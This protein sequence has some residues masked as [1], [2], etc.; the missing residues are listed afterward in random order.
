MLLLTAAA[1]SAHIGKGAIIF[2]ALAVAC[3][4]RMVYSVKWNVQTLTLKI[5]RIILF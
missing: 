4:G 3:A 1:V 2:S 5:V